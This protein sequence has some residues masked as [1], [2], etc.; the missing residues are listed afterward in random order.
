MFDAHSQQATSPAADP[1][2]LAGLVSRAA[3]GDAESWAEITDRYTPIVWAVARSH[4]LD[5]DESAAVVRAT[6][7]R[8][9]DN[10]RQVDHPDAL[11]GW[12]AATA[13][14]E[15]LGLLRR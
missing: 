10:L 6:W 11:P 14:R 15:A 7:L 13:Q 1:S 5:T 8:L 2:G 3:A 9:L 12:L 4:Q